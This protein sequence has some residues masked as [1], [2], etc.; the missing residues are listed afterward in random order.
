[1]DFQPKTA[2][3]QGGDTRK[4]PNL[5][6]HG[7]RQEG[8]GPPHAITHKPTY[9]SQ[10]LSILSNQNTLCPFT[11]ATTNSTLGYM[12]TSRMHTVWKLKFCVYIYRVIIQV[13]GIHT[14]RYNSCFAYVYT[15]RMYVPLK[16]NSSVYIWLVKMQ[17]LDIHV[18]RYACCMH[19]CPPPPTPP[20]TPIQLPLS[21][22]H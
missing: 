18:C 6:N 21:Y 5:A 14:A 1:M 19:I 17:V 11:A 4:V 16:L 7:I 13:F 22:V 20:H 2:N 15:S 3:L 12:Y 9:H 10:T 8:K